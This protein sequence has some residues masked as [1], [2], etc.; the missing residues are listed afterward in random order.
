MNAE[1]T[2]WLLH[3]NSELVEEDITARPLVHERID[4]AAEDPRAR[5]PVHPPAPMFALMRNA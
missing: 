2:F 3:C 4:T 1:R 5:T